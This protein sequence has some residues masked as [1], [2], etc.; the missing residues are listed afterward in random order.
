MR[1]E[2]QNKFA[3]SKLGRRSAE[4]LIA[5][6]SRAHWDGSSA[7]ALS[8][9]LLLCMSQSPEGDGI[10]ASARY[11]LLEDANHEAAA[12]YETAL[13]LAQ[14]T[15]PD[16]TRLCASLLLTHA[17]AGELFATDEL[18][19]ALNKR[20]IKGWPLLVPAD[21]LA[22][23]RPTRVPALWETMMKAKGLPLE[24]L[25]AADAARP[26][27]RCLCLLLALPW[28][29]RSAKEREELMAYAHGCA[30]SVALW[31]PSRPSIAT[32][33][34]GTLGQTLRARKQ[35]CLPLML[36]MGIESC[37]SQ[38]RSSVSSLCLSLSAHRSEHASQDAPPEVWRIGVRPKSN[39]F[40]LHGM[41]WPFE[42]GSQQDAYER[43]LASAT[44][45][46]IDQAYLIDGAHGARICPVC[47][48]AEFPLPDEPHWREAHE[49]IDAPLD[50]RHSH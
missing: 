20:G 47:Q 15:I 21:E 18:L 24:L 12:R 33:R 16:G 7:A 17:P 4:A 28:S 41:D 43:I 48:D 14:E 30:S 2:T 46:G 45:A 37:A 13:S 49:Q 9:A 25:A 27:L 36:R 42:P 10:I 29:G 50:G 6:A 22:G 38:S 23:L 32:L 34:T 11:E 5:S 8:Q 3:L 1:S 40:L 31:G 44:Q 19:E 35:S 26:G 39:G